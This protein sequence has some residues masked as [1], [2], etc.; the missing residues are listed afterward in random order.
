MAHKK[1]F[2]VEVRVKDWIPD[3]KS[4][5]RVVAYE[6]IELNSFGDDHEDVF[7]ARHIGYEQFVT[8]AKYTPSLQKLLAENNLSLRANSICAPDAVEIG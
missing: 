2:L 7:R 4:G 6:E 1:L 8:R 3:L 5:G